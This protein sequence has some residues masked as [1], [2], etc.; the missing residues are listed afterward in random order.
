MRLSLVSLAALSAALFAVPAFAQE[1]GHDHGDH[2]HQHDDHG[3]A[4][5]DHGHDHGHDHGDHAHTDD[6]DQQPGGLRLTAE[7]AGELAAGQDATLTLQ[8]SGPDGAPV[9]GSD[10]APT[11]GRLVHVLIV[12]EGL[13]DFHHLHIEPDAEGR[14][15]LG[16]TPAHPRIYRVWV[17]GQLSEPLDS[18]AATEGHSHGG[19]HDHAHDP[20]ADDHHAGHGE[21]AHAHDAGAVRAT[22]WVRV[23]DEA[24]P[25]IIPADILT[26]Q[27]GGLSFTLAP[28]ASIRAGMANVMTLSVADAEGAPVTTLQPHL[29]AFAHI[30]GFNAGASQMAHAHPSGAEPVTDE[31]FAGPDLTFE[32][33]F[34]EPGVHRL[35]VEVRHQGEVI[36]S[37]FTVVVRE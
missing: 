32:I 34:D 28:Q 4:H 25:Y 3:H 7:A 13:E 36:L 27:A 33:G 37:S 19:G 16:F 17:D 12:D 21:D 23:G 1:H 22:D 10:F 2:G 5:D 31:A 26:A 18:P 29:G 14:A 6:A 30:V 15:T 8:L 24:A 9:A 35:F 11:H 20:Q